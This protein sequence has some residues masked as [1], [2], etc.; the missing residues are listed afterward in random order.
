MLD[1]LWHRPTWFGLRNEELNRSDC[2]TD[3]GFSHWEIDERLKSFRWLSML[4]Q[5]G[6]INMAQISVDPDRDE[7]PFF[8][9]Q[10]MATHTRGRR[11]LDGTRAEFFVP[12][13]FSN[14]DD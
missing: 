7:I 8:C 5:H 14:L 9:L 10:A 3:A 2:L 4:V 13:Y 12:W 11:K 1:Y 6:C